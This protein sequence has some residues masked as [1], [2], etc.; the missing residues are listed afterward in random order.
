MTCYSTSFTDVLRQGQIVWARLSSQRWWPAILITAAMC[1]R[2]SPKPNHS[3][4]FWFGDHKISEVLACLCVFDV[5]VC[6][7]YDVLVCVYVL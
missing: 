4:V 1:G 2:G 5:L 7:Y 3:V 6:A